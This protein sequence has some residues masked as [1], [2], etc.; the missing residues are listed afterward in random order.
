VARIV[1]ACWGSYGD[2]FPYLAIATELKARGHT[3]VLCTCAYYQPLVEHEGFEFR[4][5]RPDVR[6]DDT[7]LLAR[8]MDP[9]RGSEVI[10]RELIVAT[11]RESYDDIT[12]AVDG[13]DLLLSHPITF[14]A[15]LVA[16]VRRMPWLASVLAP[17]SFFS[18][19]DF[20]ALPNAPRI[21]GLT[22]LTPWAGRA[23][24]AMARRITGPWVAP[25]VALRSE[26][27]LPLAGDPLYEGQFSPHANLA[28][29]SRALGEAQAD[30]P[31]GTQVTGFPFFNRAIAMPGELSAF[32]DGG[33]PPVVF[34]LGSAAVNA[35]GS[36]FDESAKAAAAVGCR[37]VLIVGPNPAN[38]PATLPAGT[39]AVEGA[40]HDQVFPRASVVVHQGGVGTTGQAMRSGKP[41]LIVP[42]AH[43][44]PDNAVRVVRLGAG[45]IVYPSRYRAP[46]VAR[47]LTTL[48]GDATIAAAA[49]A[50]GQRVRSERGAVAAADAILGVLAAGPR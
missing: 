32:L 35:A 8:V 50:V 20:P 41:E 28:L 7:A 9:Q 14:A 22:R 3:P 37:A 27:G 1:L 19:H 48:L 24:M 43:D 29:F 47:E 46:R 33:E 15:P 18:L 6:P 23:L 45:R 42:F 21:V 38:R 34:T 44:Q 39:I 12:A 25:V 5:L 36:F 40:P 26:L 4:P 30:W 49:D 16:G 17:L 31:G 11:L 10:I 2:L 13:A